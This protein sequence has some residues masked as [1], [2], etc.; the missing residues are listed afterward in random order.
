MNPIYDALPPDEVIEVEKLAR[1]MYE[2][3]GARDDLLARLGA[4][5]ADQALACI[6][7][8]DLP[9]HPSYENYLSVRILT[10]LGSQARSDLAAR[11]EAQQKR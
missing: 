7:A 4:A 9:E 8:G 11:L 6:R 10:D 3:R 5:N 2:L 1:L